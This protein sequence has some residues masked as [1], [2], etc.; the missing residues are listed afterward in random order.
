MRSVASRRM[1]RPDRSRRLP[2]AHRGP[3]GPGQDDAGCHRLGWY[4][5]FVAYLLPRPPTPSFPGFN[6]RFDSLS[7]KPN[8]LNAAFQEVFNPSVNFTILTFLK[9][10]FPIFNII[11]STVPWRVRATRAELSLSAGRACTP[12]RP[13]AR[14]H[15]P[16][17]NWPYPGEEGADRTRNVGQQERRRREEGHAGAGPTHS[18][19]EGKHGDGHP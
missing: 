11:V 3:L 9:I 15:A 2:G 8:E 6:Y 13:R 19:V 1:G 18:F 7:G 16:N 4:I 10:V 14:C 12:H 17:W 5:N